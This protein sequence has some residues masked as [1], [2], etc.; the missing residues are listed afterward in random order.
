M[1]SLFILPYKM[2]SRSSRMLAVALKARRIKVEGS[3]FKATPNKVVINWGNSVPPVAMAGCTVINKPDAVSLAG[4]KLS[5]FNAMQEA[6]VCILD[7]TSD[8]SVAKSWIGEGAEVIE[9]HQLKG[10]GGA[11]IRVV[12]IVEDLQKAPLYT[13]YFPSTDEFRVHVCCDQVVDTQQK[14]KRQE[15]EDV[16]FH[17]RNH[18]RGFVFC[19]EGVSVS[20][21]VQQECIKAV[22]SLGLDFGA[23]DVRVKKNG[24]IA[25]MEVNTAPGLEG[26]TLVNYTKVFNDLLEAMSS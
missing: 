9:R 2:A 12:S 18:D 20:E 17:V 1:K 22:R 21:R 16:D 13:K 11:G 8:L 7:Y 26:T 4:N 14:R 6:G 25:V 23:V 15:E 10:S 3:N 5:A 19:R 24:A